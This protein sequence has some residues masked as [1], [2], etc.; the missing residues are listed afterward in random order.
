MGPAAPASAAPA[1]VTASAVAGELH[2]SELWCQGSGDGSVKRPFC[3]ISEA[4]A[5]A[6]PGQTVLVHP[7]EYQ[8]N[9]RFTRSGTESAPITFRAVNVNSEMVRVGRYATGAITGTILDLTGVHDVTVEGLVVFGANV[10][11]AVTVRDS[12]RVRLDKVTIYT[13][14]SGPNGVRISGTSSRVTVSRSFVRTWQGPSV[15]VESGVTDTVITANQLDNSGLAAANAPRLTITGNTIHVDCRYGIHL[16]GSSPGATIRNNIVVTARLRG[17]CLTPANATGIRV[18]AES[19]AGTSTDYNLIDPLGGGAPYSWAGTDY[20]TLAAFVAATGQAAHDL[21]ADPKLTWATGVDRHYLVTG[22]GSPARDSAEANAPGALDTDMLDGSYTDDPAMPNIGTGSGY[23]DRGAVEARGA[24]TQ[25]PLRVER[26]V[27]GGTLDV[28]ARSGTHSVW[29]VERERTL[30]AYHLHGEPFWRVTDSA[31]AE[32]TLR[33]AGEVCVRVQTSQTDFRLPT[34]YDERICTQVGARYIPVAPTRV[35]DTRSRIGVPDTRPVAANGTVELPIGSIAGI[36]GTDISAVVLNVTV[37]QP[38]ASGF[39]SVYPSGGWS[40]SSSINFVSGETVPNQ[41]TVP[42]LDGSALFDNAS[43][44]TV[45]LVADLQGFYAATGSGFAS[46]SPTRVLDTREGAGAPIPAKGIRPLD[47]SGRLPASAKAAVLSVTVTAPTTSGVLTVFPYGSAA[48]TASNLNFVAGQ[49]IPNLVTVP[50]VNGR[51]NIFNNSSGTTHVV[52]DLAGWFSPD[53][54]QTFVPIT[55]TRIVDTRY[56]IGLPG[57]APAPLAARETVRFAPFQSGVV[58]APACPTP[59]ALVGNVTV[60]APTTAGVLT[61]HP[62]GGQRPTA[63]NVN[64]VAG[65]TASNAALVAVGSGV[66]I[67]HNSGGTSHV[68]VDQSGYFIAAAS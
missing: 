26:K 66:D 8:E 58:C 1:P 28:V 47:L 40:T 36:P 39:I 68:I 54:T 33:R 13:G 3:T 50:V 16:A 38:S 20:P 61:L 2:V 18:S 23:R 41:V 32:Y 49:T 57:R 11:D 24:V 6:G 22:D 25:D 15:S 46:M 64:F 59:T 52:A 37:T 44:G 14:S 31:T 12:H 30:Y 10:A 21:A 48:P 51:V 35:L 45:H 63:S 34:S 65:E 4:A 56:S 19:V 62:G 29:P 17:R 43:S 60:T 42:V 53:A 67:F 7:G 5:V 55:P 9:V 27:G